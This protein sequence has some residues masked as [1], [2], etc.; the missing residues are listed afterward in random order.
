ML[1]ISQKWTYDFAVSFSRSQQVSA[2]L[3]GRSRCLSYWVWLRLT[4]RFFSEGHHKISFELLNSLR[5]NL[6]RSCVAYSIRGNA[7]QSLEFSILTRAYTLR[8]NAGRPI[9]EGLSAKRVLLDQWDV[10]LPGP[11]LTWERQHTLVVVSS[12]DESN[13]YSGT[14]RDFLQTDEF[15]L[16]LVYIS[17]SVTFRTIGFIRAMVW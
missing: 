16:L 14:L 7:T 15:L 9:L 8:T 11:A 10:C 13:R 12:C 4:N 17:R 5:H 3:L 1:W 2:V 6:L